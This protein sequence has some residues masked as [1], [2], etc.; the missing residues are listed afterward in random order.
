VDIY[1]T[2]RLKELRNK[3]AISQVALAKE[4]GISRQT[5][6]RCENG[7]SEP[8]IQMIYNLCIYFDVTADYLL[9]LV[10]DMKAFRYPAFSKNHSKN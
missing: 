2:K 10:D 5:I 6:A 7:S 1:F 9:G 3:N 8:N 4:I